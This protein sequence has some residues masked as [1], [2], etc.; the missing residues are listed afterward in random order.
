MKQPAK[1]KTFAAGAQEVPM[2]DWN[3]SN[4]GHRRSER[5]T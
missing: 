3:L 4:L 2:R 5:Q 1:P